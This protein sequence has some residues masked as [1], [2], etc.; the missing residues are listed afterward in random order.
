MN[1]IKNALS[2]LEPDEKAKERV[3]KG[4]ERESKP[5]RKRVFLIAAVVAAFIF[6][7]AIGINAASGG[8]LFG[9][10]LGGSDNTSARESAILSEGDEIYAPEIIFLNKTTLVIESKNGVFVYDR[11]K[12][13]I[14]KTIDLQSVGGYYIDHGDDFGDPPVLKTHTLVEDGKIIIFNTKSGSGGLRA[15]DGDA[16]VFSMTKNEK[17]KRI[18]DD[19]EKNKYYEK[20]LKNEKNYV[21]CFDTFYNYLENNNLNG[22]DD[23]YSY[24]AYVST[25]NRKKL[26]SFIITDSENSLCLCTSYDKKSVRK[27]CFKLLSDKKY[28]DYKQKNKLPEFKYSGS[29]KVMKAIIEYEQ[30]RNDEL[31]YSDN[32]WIPFFTELCRKDDGDELKVFVEIWQFEYQ[33]QGDVL[34]ETNGGDGM[35]KYTLN[36]G[37]GGYKV[38]DVEYAS[39][40]ALLEESIKKMSE[41]DASVYMRISGRAQPNYEF[42]DMYIRDNNLNVKYRRANGEVA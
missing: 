32:V 29:D 37:K 26:Y 33:R 16:Y 39:D 6:T 21:D 23:T 41:G 25:Q 24:R 3:W 40:G 17:N 2:N 1:I 22:G 30:A 7:A 5:K 34:E 18:T 8:K 42:L 36:K 15:S 12:K 38:I 13:K 31:L 14:T 20:W 4:L 10:I 9:A 11:S 28:L 35:A 19:S 27:E